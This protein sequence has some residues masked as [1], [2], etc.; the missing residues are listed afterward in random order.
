[1]PGTGHGR[2]RS[3]PRR[4]GRHKPPRMRMRPGKRCPRASRAARRRNPR[5]RRTRC[6][7]N[8][9]AATDAPRMGMTP[10]LQVKRHGA[11]PGTPRGTRLYYRHHLHDCQATRPKS[12]GLYNDKSGV[13]FTDF[14]KK[15]VFWDTCAIFNGDL[16]NI[17]R[18]L[19]N[20]Q[21]T[22][23]QYSTVPLVYS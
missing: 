13:L 2:P 12:C 15:G 5:T 4:C 21:R 3:H 20:I 7:D 11:N 16:R 1:M 23:A 17:Q 10:P 9:P 14:Y 18:D 6:P 22:L 8:A 19:R